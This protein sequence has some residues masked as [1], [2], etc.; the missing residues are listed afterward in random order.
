LGCYYTMKKLETKIAEFNDW[1][2]PWTFYAFV[3]G[4]CEINSSELAQF[5]ELWEKASAF[6]HWNSVDLILGRKACH[7]FLAENYSLTEDTITNIV[8]AIS[9]QWR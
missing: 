3:S 2:H 9:Y 6:E 7:Y 1:S 8:R 5:R 4:D